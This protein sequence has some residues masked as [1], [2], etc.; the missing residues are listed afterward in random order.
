MNGVISSTPPPQQPLNATS[1]V[2]RTI[3]SGQSHTHASPADPFLLKRRFQT[4]I[5]RFSKRLTAILKVLVLPLRHQRSLE[6][7]QGGNPAAA[8]HP[9]N[10]SCC[11]CG[12]SSFEK[13]Q[14]NP[15]VTNRGWFFFF[16]FRL[17]SSDG[18]FIARDKHRRSARATRLLDLFLTPALPTSGPAS[19]R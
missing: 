4:N 2:I 12:F 17:Q 7:R 15:L 3:P 13:H 16:N 1:F 18:G 11:G 5:Y 8:R 6:R 19:P 10:P 14:R 9:R